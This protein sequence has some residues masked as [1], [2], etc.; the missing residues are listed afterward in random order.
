M[1]N[2]LKNPYSYIIALGALCV[3]LIGT[4]LAGGKPV[5]EAS[6]EWSPEAL[7]MAT[8]IA[9]DI[10]QYGS[11]STLVEQGS[12]MMREAEAAAKGKDLV[13]CAEFKARYDRTTKQLVTDEACPLL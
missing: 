10:E 6:A 12:K 11:G 9:D 5:P 1:K 7:Q 13:L 4:S 2:I 3:L 8:S